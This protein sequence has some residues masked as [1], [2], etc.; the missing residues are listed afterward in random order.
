MKHRIK[1]NNI[2]SI[3]ILSKNS[4]NDSKTPLNSPTNIVISN[5]LN[6][7]IK[8]NLKY[9]KFLIN[10]D[11]FVNDLYIYIY[12]VNL[13]EKLYSSQ[14]VKNILKESLSEFLRKKYILKK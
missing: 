9:S 12:P 5:L 6:K 3:F 13:E 7:E 11:R 14:V 10:F 8:Q 4:S 2:T 1:K